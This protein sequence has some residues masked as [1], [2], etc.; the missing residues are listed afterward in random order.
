MREQKQGL[1][2]VCS[3]FRIGADGE[4]ASLLDKFVVD[5]TTHE[6][7]RQIAEAAQQA[8]IHNH[9]FRTQPQRTI[10]GVPNA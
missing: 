5:F 10:D 1:P 6:G 7:R 9:Q 3:T 8:M 2:V 4:A